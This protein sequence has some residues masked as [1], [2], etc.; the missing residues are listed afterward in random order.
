MKYML[1]AATV[2]LLILMPLG[3]NS[4]AADTWSKQIEAIKEQMQE[5]QRQSQQQI[6]E[7]QRKIQELEA[8]EEA[9]QKKVEELMSRQEEEDEDAWW[10]KVEIGYKKPGDGF[11]IETKD[12]NF[13]L[14]TR[15]REQIQFRVVDEED[16]NTETTFDIRRLR[17]KFDGNAF[18][19]WLFYDIQVDA[20]DDII[21]RDAYFDAAYDTRFAPR[22]GQYKVPFS[23]EELNSSSE[24]QLV[25][26]SILNDEF[27]FGRDIGAGTYGV[28]GKLITY[29]VGVFNGNGRNEDSV[30][31]NLLY[32][33]R[34]MFTPC[35][36]EVEYKP[37]SFPIGGDYNMEPNFGEDVP[38]IAIGIAGAVIPGLSIAD[39]TPDNDIDVRFEE[40]FGVDADDFTTEE[41]DVYEGTVDVNFKYRIFSLEGD[42]FLRRIDPDGGF[43]E[44][45]D[46]G[47]RVQGGIFLIPEFIEVA[48]RFALI[49]FDDDVDGRDLAYEI[50][51][52]VNIYLSKSHKYKLQF[53]YSFIRDEDTDGAESDENAF[54]AQFQAYF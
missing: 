6:E 1:R 12:G 31:S 36:G 22:G 30:D 14:R 42:Y 44:A 9:D 46:Q 25:E 17:I 23:R 8:G 16:D 53:S 52:G 45:T 34:I 37:G 41:G 43:E 39:K 40:I 10:K 4:K 49:D 2:G 24:L 11:T 28:L 33:G 19:P 3:A 7:L 54:R 29:G 5:I 15:L 27:A 35:C 18:T 47:F 20:T 38:L 51:P 21:L 50:T 32:A 13:K 26:R 48:G